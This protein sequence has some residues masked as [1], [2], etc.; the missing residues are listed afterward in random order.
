MTQGFF[1]SVALRSDNPLQDSLRI[2]TLWFKFG[3]EEDVTL[4]VNEGASMVSV[5]TWLDVIPQVYLVYWSLNTSDIG[6]IVDCTDPDSTVCSTGY[7]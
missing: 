7:D 4:A 1:R 3:V 6:T 5:D 2:L